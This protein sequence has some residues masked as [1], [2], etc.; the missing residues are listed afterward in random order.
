MKGKKL[1]SREKLG[2]GDID[3]LYRQAATSPCDVISYRVLIRPAWIGTIYLHEA[4]DDDVP[5]QGGGRMSP[6]A[7]LCTLERR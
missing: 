4:V 1:G 6:A 3:P 7:G 5:E 2:G